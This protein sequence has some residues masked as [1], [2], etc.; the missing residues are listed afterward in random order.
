MRNQIVLKHSFFVELRQLTFRWM[1]VAVGAGATILIWLGNVNAHTSPPEIVGL[2]SA[3][4]LICALS[5][6]LQR[7]SR[8]L[9]FYLFTGGLW[10][11]NAV[12]FL[13]LRLDVFG[14]VFMLFAV[15]S[16]ALMSRL[17]SVALGLLSSAFL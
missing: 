6:W 12:A 3:L 15:I 16:G 13:S 8:T 1:I 5:W 11:C 9:A 17:A 4:E 10:L 7:R 14:Y 2:W